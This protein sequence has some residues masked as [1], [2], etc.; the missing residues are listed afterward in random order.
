MKPRQPRV[1]GESRMPALDAGVETIDIGVGLW[2]L[3][4]VQFVTR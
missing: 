1:S 2:L 3:R 4:T